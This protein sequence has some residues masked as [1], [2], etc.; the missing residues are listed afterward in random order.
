VKKILSF[1]LITVSSLAMENAVNAACPTLNL[2]NLAEARCAEI[3]GPFMVGGMAYVSKSSSECKG[4]DLTAVRKKFQAAVQGPKEYRGQESVIDPGKYTC[5][6]QLTHD[7]QQKLGTTDTSFTLTSTPMVKDLLTACPPIAV[8]DVN[9]SLSKVFKSGW[10]M[11]G[12]FRIPDVTVIRKG[13]P[14]P[15][16]GKLTVIKPFGHNCTYTHHSGA[17]TFTLV[18]NQRVAT[19]QTR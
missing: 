14:Q 2:S 13:A 7:W 18:G 19:T 16:Q 4:L 9:P 10:T 17:S 5:T 11:E 15:L 12:Q 6:Y 8:P 3:T 1:V